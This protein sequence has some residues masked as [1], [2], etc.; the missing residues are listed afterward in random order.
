MLRCGPGASCPE[1]HLMTIAI[2]QAAAN[3]GTAVDE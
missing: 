2:T 1:A 3:L